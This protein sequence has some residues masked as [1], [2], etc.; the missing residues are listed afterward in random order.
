MGEGRI[1]HPARSRE[2]PSRGGGRGRAV[3]Y[4]EMPEDPVGLYGANLYGIGRGELPA[5]AVQGSR[6]VC[7]RLLRPGHKGPVTLKTQT[8]SSIKRRG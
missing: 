7:P 5:H 3:F 1:L 2:V 8:R 6:K 4:A